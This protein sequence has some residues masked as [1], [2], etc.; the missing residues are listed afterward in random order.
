MAE[1]S[2]LRRFLSNFRGGAINY[3]GQ[4]KTYQNILYRQFAGAKDV[5]NH[6]AQSLSEKLDDTEIIKRLISQIETK[7]IPAYFTV[8]Q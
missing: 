2:F 7:N 3:P 5:I 1:S 8:S 4:L 6:L